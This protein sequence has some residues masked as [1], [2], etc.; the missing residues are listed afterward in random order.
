MGRK[1]SAAIALSVAGGSLLA[2]GLWEGL[3]RTDGRVWPSIG[4]AVLGTAGLVAAFQAFYS[5]RRRPLAAGVLTIAVPW[6]GSTS[7][8][9]G[10]DPAASWIMLRFT[11]SVRR[12]SGHITCTVKRGGSVVATASTKLKR[13]R[14]LEWRVPRWLGTSDGG[15]VYGTLS[16]RSLESKTAVVRLP[17]GVAKDCI[18]ELAVDL[19][20]SFDGTDLARH[21]PVRVGEMVSV[22]VY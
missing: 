9:L 14:P 18:I 3:I 13:H 6:K 17:K 20:S 15:Q 1:P 2:L 21:H 4:W 7:L 5:N 12:F 10:P 16:A 11:G 22:E 19:T 8:S